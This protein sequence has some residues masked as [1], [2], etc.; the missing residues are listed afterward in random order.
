MLA[1]SPLVLASITLR[2]NSFLMSC[3]VRGE[4]ADAAVVVL[5]AEEV[6]AENGSSL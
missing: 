1:L 3:A 2:A 6:E 4:A 5:A